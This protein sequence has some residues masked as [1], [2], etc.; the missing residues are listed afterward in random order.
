MELGVGGSNPPCCTKIMSK[1]KKLKPELASGFIDRKGN[2]LILKDRLIE[3]IKRNFQLYGFEPLETPGFEISENIGKF[4]PDED[5]PMS[6]VFGFKDYKNWISLRY[7]LTAPLAR[8]FAANENLISK[9]FK[10]YQVGTVWRNEKPGPG[11]F[12]E[13]T[14]IDAD[15]VGTKNIL[16]DADMCILL[17][18]TLNKCGLDKN[19][20]IIRVSNRKCFFGIL[21][22]LG[23][24][25]ERQRIAITRAVDK[26]D[27]IGIEGVA[28]LLGKGRKDKSGDFTKGVGLNKKQ[29][30]QITEYIEENT[31]YDTE[32]NANFPDPTKYAPLAQYDFLDPL[33]DEG[34]KELSNFFKNTRLS[35]FK[36]Q[37]VYS[38]TLVRGI[39]YYT[40]TIFEANLL[41]KVKN[42]KGQ[43][44][45]FGSVGGGGRYDD[46][47]SRFTNNIAPATG[48][49]IGLD[50]LLV[51]VQQRDNFWKNNNEIE[52]TGPVVICLF[53][54]NEKDIAP[55]YK[56]LTMLR[57]AG[58]KSEVYSGD[59]SIKSQMK[60]A[61]KRNSPAVIL[62][63]ENEAKSGTVTIKNLKVGKESSKDIKTREDWKS[64]K[65]AQVTVKL[66]NLID[67][68]K[69][70]I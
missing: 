18:D 63:G 6:G 13:F 20:F 60:Y 2:E 21:N 41:F 61:D 35:E 48:V 44:V 8:Y 11:R 15:I 30:K 28:S 68:I 47:V 50:R 54:I 29:I 67:E 27:R 52:N 7:D 1:E 22:W 4:L 37:I 33:Y 31:L 9:P 16:A 24:S 70:N 3:I 53:E 17:A 62:Y 65:S 36:N 23:I 43:E 45:E 10:R 57:S 42:Q 19:E 14:Q 39:E 46:L 59:S 32:G 40:G 55:Y 5:R 38:P 66:E 12:K 26:Y 64:N 34:Q 69:K 56:I 25:S 58:I 51:G 49:S